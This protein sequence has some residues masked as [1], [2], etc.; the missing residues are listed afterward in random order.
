MF[1]LPSKRGVFRY[2]LEQH[3]GEPCRPAS[4]LRVVMAFD[5]AL[6][7]FD[8]GEMLDSIGMLLQRPLKPRQFSADGRLPLTLRQPARCKARLL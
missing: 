2:D 6:Q 5:Y 8:P 7:P 4:D 3:V 1:L